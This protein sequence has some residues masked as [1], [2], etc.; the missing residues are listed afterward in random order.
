MKVLPNNRRT[1]EHLHAKKITI[2]PRGVNKSKEG[3]HRKVNRQNINIY[4]IINNNVLNKSPLITQE[5]NSFVLEKTFDTPSQLL[6]PKPKSRHEFELEQELK[7][8]RSEIEFRYK[9]SNANQTYIY[10]KKGEKVSAGENQY[11]SW[12]ETIPVSIYKVD[13][14][15]RDNSGKK[16]LKI[17]QRKPHSHDKIGLY[18]KGNIR[19]YIQDM[20]KTNLHKDSLK[21][22]TAQVSLYNDSFGKH[23]QK[24]VNSKMK[25]FFCSRS[26]KQDNTRLQT[27]E[28]LYNCTRKGHN[29]TNTFN[30]LETEVVNTTNNLKST[31]GKVT[32]Y[33]KAI[34]TKNRNAKSRSMNRTKITIRNK[35]SKQ[36]NNTLS[37]NTF[38]NYNLKKIK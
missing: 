11:T 4:N 18:I 5:P 35:E 3:H 1:P 26:D 33:F 23:A 32:D 21:K 22:H 15:E 20:I 31:T 12:T 6:K 13:A 16:R 24:V 29:R 30:P 25:S 34:I 17:P 37:L 9:N 28:G 7:L 27:S 8:Y 36:F 10:P 38:L 19:N 2:L 14:L